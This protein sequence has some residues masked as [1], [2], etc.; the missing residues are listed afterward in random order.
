MS[1]YSFKNTLALA[2]NEGFRKWIKFGLTAFI[3]Y[4]I[5]KF[6][7]PTSVSV[8]QEDNTRTIIATPGMNIRNSESALTIGG[9]LTKEK[10]KYLK[11]TKHPASL[12]LKTLI[13]S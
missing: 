3:E 13:S 6:S 5:R 7:M 9:V 8:T 2:M 1:Y 12:I 4:D 10:G 11:D